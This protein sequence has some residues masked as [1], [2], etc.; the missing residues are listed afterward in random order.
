MV[1]SMPFVVLRSDMLALAADNPTL[2]ERLAKLPTW[3]VP[4]ES[5]G[6]NIVGQTQAEFWD[7]MEREDTCTAS[8]LSA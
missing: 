4:T 1:A 5:H 6:R 2:A 7:A 3:P 8:S